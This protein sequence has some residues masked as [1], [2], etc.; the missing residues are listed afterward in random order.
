MNETVRIH[1]YPIQLD[2]HSPFEFSIHLH[3]ETIDIHTYIIWHG[4]YHIEGTAWESC[5]SNII[6][7]KEVDCH[8]I[9]YN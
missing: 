7:V 2:L 8:M 1:F 5:P 3:T 9:S 6:A 4:N